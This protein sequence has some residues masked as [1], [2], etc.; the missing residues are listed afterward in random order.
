MGVFY[1]PRVSL[2]R[3]QERPYNAGW[4]HLRDARPLAAQNG[5]DSNKWFGHTEKTMLLLEQ[6]RYY[7]HAAS[8][9]CR[10]SKTVKYVSQIQL[11]YDHYDA[12]T[13]GRLRLTD[14]GI[15][16]NI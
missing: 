9:Y 7:R 8:G 11:R 3:K 6:P 16:T 4:S 15:V 1:S 12:V 10:G 2:S 13:A 14:D 5:W